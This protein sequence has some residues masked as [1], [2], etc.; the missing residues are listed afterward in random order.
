MKQFPARSLFRSRRG[1]SV[2]FLFLLGCFSSL[3]F[4][5]GVE[6]L[7][8]DIA[9]E[10]GSVATFNLTLSP[11]DQDVPVLLSLFQPFQEESGSIAYQKVDAETYPPIDW[12]KLPSATVTVRANERLDV[13]IEVD[14]PFGTKGTYIVTLM[15]E[16]QTT[17]TSG[18]IVF[19]IRYAIR[20]TIRVSAAGLRETATVERFEI[21]PDDRGEPTILV[22]LLNDSR[23]DYLASM[24][25]SVRDSRGRLLERVPLLSEASVSSGR[26][27]TRMYPGA[28]VFFLG[29][30]EKILSPDLYK[31]QILARYNETQRI[32]SEE[33]QVSASEFVF[34]EARDLY[35]MFKEQNIQLDLKPRSVKTQII[36]VENQSAEAVQVKVHQE[37]VI[38]NDP[39]SIGDWLTIRGQ[40]EF[41]LVPGRSNRLV[42]TLKIP[43]AAKDGTYYSKIVYTAYKE[44]EPQVTKSVLLAVV[45]GSQQKEVQFTS[46]SFDAMPS[47][48]GLSTLFQN[49]GSIHISDCTAELGILNPVDKTMVSTAQLEL[50]RSG[51]IF[52]GESFDL[53]GS[54]LPR[55]EPG[56]YLV[57][58]RLL[59][60]GQEIMTFE[61]TL[62]VPEAS[63]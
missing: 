59:E 2:F 47:G 7:S 58:G 20:I 4:A 40:S 60:K 27:S 62:Q 57:R 23:L 37:D 43:D 15:V 36:E 25:V 12:V 44:Q 56:E 24:N 18:M 38:P 55:L 33:F 1:I 35:L 11:E 13:P 45:I 26:D 16:P 21:V 63:E 32:Y 31:L 39:N 19:R 41:E 48:Q 54:P 10:P 8:V 29:K 5:I 9:G 34:P 42:A 51:W 28:A 3:L 22:K 52:P 61:T 6:P 14:I 17:S 46:L 49:V 30:P 53:F 50:S